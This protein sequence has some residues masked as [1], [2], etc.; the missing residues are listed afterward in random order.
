MVEPPYPIASVDNALRLLQ[1]LRDRGSV[2]LTDVAGELGIAASTTHRLMAML[3]YRGFAVQ[4][5]SRR[6]S[7]GPALGAR[8]IGSSWSRTLRLT[9]Q[10]LLEQLCER[11]DETVNLIVRTGASV[12]FLDSVEASSLL[13]VG[14]RAGT[15]LPARSTSGGK[16]LLAREPTDYLARLYLSKGAALAG[17]QLDRREFDELLAELA[18]VRERGY[19]VNREETETGIGAIGLAIDGVG[20]RA[21]AAFSVAVPVSRLDQLFRPAAVAELIEVRDELSATLRE[22]GIGEPGTP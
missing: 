19:A 14:D 15:V 22:L 20:D 10:P 18:T 13:R 6:Y 17:H 21:V 7:P 8:V 3:V 9:L 4:D 5:D 16:A 12:R 1:I 2:R 11:L